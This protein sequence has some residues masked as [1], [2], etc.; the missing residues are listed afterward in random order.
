MIQSV[1]QDIINFKTLSSQVKFLLFFQL[2][3]L[4]IVSLLVGFIFSPDRG[5]KIVKSPIIRPQTQA[6]TQD[7][8]ILKISPSEAV[9]KLG[10]EQTFTV[11][12]V[13]QPVPA[14]DVV[15]SFDTKYLEISAVSPAAE[16]D[17]LIVNSIKDNRIYY[18]A[19]YSPDKWSEAHPG[20][21]FSFVAK[22]VAKSEGTALSI[23]KEETSTSRDNKNTLVET[24]DSIVRIYD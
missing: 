11:E 20:A 6:K 15:I 14:T 24:V 1:K 22:A 18:S 4:F 21:I 23:V 17:N 10:Q 16:F 2:V 8:T 12:L 7:G 13:G 5:A 3:V 19:N 9:F